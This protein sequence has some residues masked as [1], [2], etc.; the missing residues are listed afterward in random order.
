MTSI[1]LILGFISLMHSYC[2]CTSVRRAF[3]SIA[4]WM[5]GEAQVDSESKDAESL[6]WIMLIWHGRIAQSDI[7]RVFVLKD[8]GR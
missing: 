5:Q 3:V 7:E 1:S 6:R 8:L 2:R 4:K